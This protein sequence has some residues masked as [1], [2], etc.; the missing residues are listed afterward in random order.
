[1]SPAV[2]PVAYLRSRVQG[3]SDRVADAD[4]HA[5]G[6]RRGVAQP[7]DDRIP[8]FRQNP[9][10]AIDAFGDGC[11]AAFNEATGTV[12]GV[13]VEKP[14]LAE[15]ARPLGVDDVVVLHRDIDVI[16]HAAAKGAGGVLDD[17]H[18]RIGRFRDSSA[19]I[20]LT[21]AWALTQLDR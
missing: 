16:T 15:H 6:F 20:S 5:L 4:G 14:G 13:V 21:Q 10:G 17:G 3:A 8:R 2:L 12:V 11:W 1:K 19:H 18:G 7:V 9:G